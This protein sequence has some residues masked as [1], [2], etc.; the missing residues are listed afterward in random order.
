MLNVWC[1]FYDFDWRSI[2]IL[3]KISLDRRLIL[4]LFMAEKK[5][6]SCGICNKQFDK[7]FNLLLIPIYRIKGIISTKRSLDYRTYK[8]HGVQTEKETLHKHIHA[9]MMFWRTE[10]DFWC[11]ECN[12]GT[13]EDIN[14]RNLWQSMCCQ[15]NFQKYQVIK[16]WL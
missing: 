10:V 8:V 7:V 4:K 11:P 3:D 15:E 16:Q 9:S 14:V 13:K 2:K 6:Y 12:F 5:P 1:R